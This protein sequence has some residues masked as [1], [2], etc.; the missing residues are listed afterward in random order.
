MMKSPRRATSGRSRDTSG[1]RKLRLDRPFAADVERRAWE[2]TQRYQIVVW[3]EDGEYYGRGFEM[4][5]AMG[6]G[7]TPDECVKNTRQGILAAV[8]TMLEAG[9]SPPP[10]ASD[11]ARTEQINVRLTPREKIQLEAAA[12]EQGYRGVS[13]YVR[14]VALVKVAGANGGTG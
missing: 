5:G 6:D 9:E 12:A 2:L 4:P 11:G 14:A 10:P 7:K 3:F 13:D 1:K 8:A